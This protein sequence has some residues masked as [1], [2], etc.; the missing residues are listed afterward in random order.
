LTVFPFRAPR[1]VIYSGG[2]H[3]IRAHGAQEAFSLAETR[4]V[5]IG[6][7]IAGLSAA[8]TARAQDPGCAI[9]LLTEDPH[10]PYYRQRQC[11]VLEDRAAAQKLVIHPKEWYTIRGISLRLGQAVTGIDTQERAVALKDGSRL[12]YDRLVL[13]TGSASVVP[14]IQGADLPGVETLWTMEDALRIESRLKDARRAIVIGGGLLGLEAAYA[15]HKRGIDNAILERLPRLMMRQLDERA[16][17]LFTRQVEKEGSEVTT[18]ASV[19]EIYADRAGRAAGV[20]LADGSQ[21]PA[22]LVLISA[23]VR[24][25]TEI[26]TGSGV[27]FDRFIQVDQRMRTNVPDVYAAGDCAS[28]DGRWYGLWMVAR[29]QGEAAGHNAAGGQR[30]YAAKTPPYMVNTMGTHIASA[31]LTQQEGMTSDEI[32]RAYADV[33]ENSEMFQYAKKLYLNEHLAGFI[34][35]G[36]TRAFSSLNKELAIGGTA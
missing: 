9:T 33:M 15:F 1:A 16:A 8:E 14:P 12:P 11:E 3:T 32:A 24:A 28:L 4:I 20:R 30:A 31:G 7:S 27:A 36:D 17:E 29:G 22:D 26:L 21:H 5:I 34:L 2:S 6:G 10:L 18:G 25:R 13:A 35:L 19:A 23:G